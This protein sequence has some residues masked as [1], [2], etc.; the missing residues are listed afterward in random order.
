MCILILFGQFSE[1]LE[2]AEAK[3]QYFNYNLSTVET[4]NKKNEEALKKS[5]YKRTVKNY[6]S[7]S[8]ETVNKVYTFKQKFTP[9]VVEKITTGKESQFLQNF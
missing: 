4:D 1:T 7:D 9:A 2:E 5:R 3:L 6:S 8:E